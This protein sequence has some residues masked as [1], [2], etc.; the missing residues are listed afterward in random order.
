MDDASS[1]IESAK[2]VVLIF[3]HSTDRQA[4]YDAIEALDLSLQYELN[5]RKPI[6][7]VGVGSNS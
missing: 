1:V 2:K 5:E 4:L 7:V 3:R 6:K